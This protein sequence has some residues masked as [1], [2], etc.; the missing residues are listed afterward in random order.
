MCSHEADD[1]KSLIKR[2]PVIGPTA[3]KFA[4]LPVVTRARSLAFRGSSLYW[5]LRYRNGGTSGAG[6]YRP[7]GGIQ[8]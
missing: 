8:G 2:I 4:R 1:L 6:S 3:R 7:A 5:Q